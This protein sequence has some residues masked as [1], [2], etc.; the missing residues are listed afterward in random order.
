M[1]K[2]VLLFVFLAGFART[3]VI[4]NYDYMETWNWAGVWFTPAPTTGWFT[5]AF[6]SPNTS[7]VIYGQG[8]GTSANEQDW[9][10]LPNVT[11]L[12]PT[13]SYQFRF[14]LASYAFSNPISTSRGVDAADYISVQISTNGGAT[15]VTELRITGNSNATW[16]YTSTG[17][18]THIANGVFTNT[19]APAGDIYTAPAGGGVTSPTFINLNL[20]AGIT[21]IA[22]DLFCRVNAA[23]EEWWIDNVELVELPALPVEM[24]EFVGTNTQQGNMI[25]WKTA[26]EH[27]SDY[28][29]IERSTSGEFDETS[30]IANKTAAGWSTEIINYA[31]ID[32]SFQRGI[33]YYQLTQV[34][35]DGQFKT[36][37]PIAIDNTHSGVIVKLINALG[38][39]VPE[40]ATGV[41]FE[42]YSDGSIRQVIR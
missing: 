12:D 35:R 36:Y 3:Q 34:D 1:N 25:V 38:Q 33:N 40:T 10:S 32:N 22:V 5:N 20:P 8:N 4:I 28:Y 27:N 24:I 37:G 39:Q 21:Q 15:Y 6:V 29:L 2:L 42:I 31:Y 41:L 13:K 17:T 9:Y 26:S 11:G 7:A 30:I 14:R 23:G 18:I 19:A 16:P